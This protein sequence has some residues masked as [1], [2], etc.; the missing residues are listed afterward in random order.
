MGTTPLT[1][2]EPDIIFST[3]PE[4]VEHMQSLTG[5]W[6]EVR[7]PHLHAVRWY[8]PYSVFAIKL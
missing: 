3:F 2:E 7:S 4:F 1:R 5:E 6:D 8:I